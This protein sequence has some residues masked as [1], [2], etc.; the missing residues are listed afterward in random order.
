MSMEIQN[1]LLDWSGTLADDL[2]PVVDA[3]NQVLGHYGKPAFTRDEFCRAFKLPFADFYDEVLPGVP[4][5]ELD[6]L[7]TRFFDASDAVVE[8]LPGARRFLQH[9][10]DTGKRVFLLSSIKT[11]HFEKQ[12]ASLGFR[13]YFEHPYTEVWDKRLRIGDILDT[14]RLDRSTT[15]FAGDMRHDIDTARHAGVTA[16][17]TLTGYDSHD[18][19]QASGPDWIVDDLS[20]LI[21]RL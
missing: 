9:C 20:S 6:P 19:L 13:D 18:E 10:A 16:V 11:H 4:M 2:P 3:T 5:S 12:S 1:V 17:A 14:H 21:G 15:L 8:E 7:Y